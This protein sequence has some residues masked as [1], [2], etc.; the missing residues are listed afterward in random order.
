L[1]F[2]AV[3]GHLLGREYF[4]VV[5]L[6][7]LD[8][9]A[10][11]QLRRDYAGRIWLAGTLIAVTFSIPLLNLAAPV[12]GTAFML[13]RF[14]RLGGTKVETATP[15]RAGGTLVGLIVAVVLV[16][17]LGACQ[18]PP[19]AQNPPPAKVAAPT[20][21]APTPKPVI[22]DR[23]KPPE[24]TRLAPAPQPKPKPPPDPT[25]L[26]GS[27]TAQLE[28][29]LGKPTLTHGYGDARVWQY[30]SPHCVID[31][32][33]YRSDQGYKVTHIDSRARRGDA[34]AAPDCYKTLLDQAART[35]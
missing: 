17:S 31:F 27:N 30:T 23:V 8:P 32:F 29:R 35:R 12:L 3:N 7:R 24:I 16:A 14:Q 34:P 10:A 33:L 26:V 5:A 19:A 6:R 25:E 4:E 21:A 13:H 1:L 22:K 20:A 28:R 9:Q 15:S 2:Y 11:R 18:S